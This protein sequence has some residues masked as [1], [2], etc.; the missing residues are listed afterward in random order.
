[1]KLDT[2]LAATDLRDAPDH[3]LEN[4]TLLAAIVGARLHVFHCVERGRRDT[5]EAAERELASRV[6]GEARIAVGAGTP[7]LAISRRARQI[8]A[9]I[10]VLGARRPHRGL[11]SL[12]GSTSDRVLR[13]TRVPCLLSNG[14]LPRAPEMIL[15][16]V[17]GSSHSERAIDHA[18]WLAA[19]FRSHAGRHAAIHLLHISAFAEPGESSIDAHLQLPAVAAELAR[20]VENDAEVTHATH[21]AAFTSDGILECCDRLDPDIVLMGTHGDGPFVRA[22]LGGVALDVAHALPKP[23]LLIPKPAKQ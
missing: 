10:V 15:V 2:L 20:R 21:S 4:G 8:G 3:A 13:T 16:P 17:D 1:M 22:L 23:V 14:V 5:A 9:G 18:A 7:H 19:R 12:L 6:D 11:M